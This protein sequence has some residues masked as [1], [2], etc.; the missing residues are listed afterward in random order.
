MDNL[1]TYKTLNDADKRPETAASRGSRLMI[2]S[3]K[4]RKSNA[5]E[6]LELHIDNSDYLALLNQQS[7]VSTA[8]S[9]YKVTDNL[10]EKDPPGTPI[11][12]P[13][14]RAIVAPLPKTFVTRAGSLMLFSD[15]RVVK[16]Q[17][18]AKSDNTAG[19]ALKLQGQRLK[20]RAIAPQAYSQWGKL[21]RPQAGVVH[22]NVKQTKR[23]QRNYLGLNRGEERHAYSWNYSVVPIKRIYIKPLTKSHC[24][25]LNHF[26]EAV[27]AYRAREPTEQDKYLSM[28]R[29]TWNGKTLEEHTQR[30]AARDLKQ[31]VSPWT[32]EWIQ[33]QSTVM[34]SE[35]AVSTLLR[36][37]KYGTRVRGDQL[38]TIA[39]ARSNLAVSSFCR[40]PTNTPMPGVK[41]VSLGESRVI[42]IHVPLMTYNAKLS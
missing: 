15:S 42:P 7:A 12:V 27:L 3:G 19:V 26:S 32:K 11:K 6:K 21:V 14:P 36:R 10:P 22:S 18:S 35:P 16:S 28:I 1:M 34:Y 29:Q 20:P 40:A 8:E 25:F 37:R 33:S 17:R 4:I 30:E 9:M 38:T 31:V 23:D 24:G 41:R 13:S 39:D 5:S 2:G